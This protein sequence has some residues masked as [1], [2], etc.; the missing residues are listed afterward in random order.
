MT[1]AALSG[2][3]LSIS[4]WPAAAVADDAESP[5][6]YVRQ[7]KPLLAKH[8][9]RCHGAEKQKSEFRVDSGKALLAGGKIGP[10]ETL[11]FEIELISFE[12]PNEKPAAAASQ[13]QKK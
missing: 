10:N 6:D 2:A 3:A 9:A 13:E 11:K 7:V 12:Q 8:C 1:R 5:I 4:C